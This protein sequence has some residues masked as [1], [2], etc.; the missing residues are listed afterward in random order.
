MVRFTFER[1]KNKHGHLAVWKK[2]FG[3]S[4]KKKLV[5]YLNQWQVKKEKFKDLLKK[6]VDI[7]ILYELPC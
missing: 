2:Q 3:F 1:R 4:K 5:N 7:L 6:K